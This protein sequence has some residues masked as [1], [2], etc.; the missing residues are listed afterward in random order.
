MTVLPTLRAIIRLENKVHE[1]ELLKKLALFFDE[2]YY[3]LPELYVVRR[4][5]LINGEIHVIDLTKSTN[6]T[7]KNFFEFLIDG[8]EYEIAPV[9][10]QSEDSL[11]DGLKETLLSLHAQGIA[12]RSPGI[13]EEEEKQFLDL[14]KTLALHD[15]AS[16]DFRNIFAIPSEYSLQMDLAAKK[17]PLNNAAFHIPIAILPPSI[18]ASYATSASLYL[19]N[20]TSSFP[21]FSKTHER[22]VLEYRYEQYKKGLAKALESSHSL[23]SEAEFYARF[24]DV[25]FQ[26]SNSLISSEL[27]SQKTTQEIIKYRSSMQEARLRFISQNLMELTSM[28]Y[29]NPWDSKTKTEIQKYIYG[30]LSQD[31]LQYN[32]KSKEMWEKLFGT[33]PNQLAEIPKSAI[34]GSGAGGLLGQL[35]PHTSSWYMLLLG[36]LIGAT[37]QTPSIVKSIVDV[38]LEDKKERKNSIAYI[39]NFK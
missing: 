3:Y 39:A 21:I 13:H 25:T 37:T 11:N 23:V 26:I 18:H 5:G 28:A 10:G 9:L 33:L 29:N 38:I 36:A 14:R 17:Q 35:I 12:L 30:K 24:G 31:V 16:E 27:L 8:Q 15:A 19:S 4:K 2:I 34:L 1:H 20:K 6:I 7:Q 22:Q 32:D